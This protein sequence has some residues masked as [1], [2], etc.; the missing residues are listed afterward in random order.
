M[1]VDLRDKKTNQNRIYS[2]FCKTSYKERKGNIYI[3][4]IPKRSIWNYRKIGG[5]KC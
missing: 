5:L 4:G 1:Y 3:A 2:W